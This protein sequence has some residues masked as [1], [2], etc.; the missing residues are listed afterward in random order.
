MQTGIFLWERKIHRPMHSLWISPNVRDML[1]E[2]VGFFLAV[3][4]MVVVYRSSNGSMCHMRRNAAENRQNDQQSSQS[5]SHHGVY[6]FLLSIQCPC[7]RMSYI[8]SGAGRVFIIWTGITPRTGSTIISAV[9]A[10]VI[11]IPLSFI[12]RI[13]VDIIACHKLLPE[14]EGCSSYEPGLRRE[15]AAQSSVQS[16]QW[17][18]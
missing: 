12:S 3:I 11:S 14:P 4:V 10:I 13:S 6:L 7:Y 1:S 2:K 5:N 18:S 15:P 9:I 8:S 17:S 16:K